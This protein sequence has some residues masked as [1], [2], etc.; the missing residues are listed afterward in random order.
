[1]IDRSGISGN[2]HL[3][4]V[5]AQTDQIL[6][7]SIEHNL[8][9][10]VGLSELLTAL[11]PGNPAIAFDSVKFNFNNNA[12]AWSNEDTVGGSIDKT[13]TNTVVSVGPTPQSGCSITCSFELLASEYNGNTINELTL[14]LKG[15]VP[16]SS[17]KTLFSR[18]RRANIAKTS[19]IRIEGTWTINFSV[20]VA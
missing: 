7:E 2:V 14:W 4:I 19:S 3:K 9:V 13:L 20:V 18:I 8:V 16:G 12:V 11:K 1:M 17:V 10:A 15:G 6:E 5:D